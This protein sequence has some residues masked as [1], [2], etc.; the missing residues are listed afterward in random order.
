MQ[1]LKIIILIEEKADTIQIID[2]NF[3]GNNSN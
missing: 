3:Q 1:F 2:N